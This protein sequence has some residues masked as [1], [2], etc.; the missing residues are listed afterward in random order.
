MASDFTNSAIDS[1]DAPR[2]VVRNMVEV[3]E[4]PSSVHIN[5]SFSSLAYP[6]FSTAFKRAAVEGDAS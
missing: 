4:V 1:R 6:A 3:R 2:V 5:N